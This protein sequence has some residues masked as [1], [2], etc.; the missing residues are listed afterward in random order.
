MVQFVCI[1]SS[2]GLIQP[3]IFRVY[4]QIQFFHHN[5]NAPLLL[6]I[7]FVQAQQSTDPY[8]TVLYC[9]PRWKPCYKCLT[10]LC[11]SKSKQ[12]NAFL[13]LLCPRGVDQGWLCAIELT[14][15]SS[16]DPITHSGS[17]RIHA[18]EPRCKAA[19][20]STSRLYL[21]AL[22]MKCAFQQLISMKRE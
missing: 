3:S 6:D 13:P 17:Q 16:S 11:C 7:L 2:T 9:T 15:P 5:F 4:V 8:C 20:Q 18:E 21:A 19:T 12:L 10:T 14:W 1:C 22:H